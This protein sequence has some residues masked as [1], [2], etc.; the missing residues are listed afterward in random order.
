MPIEL[1]ARARV[2]D[3]KLADSLERAGRILL[4]ALERGASELEITLV[5]DDEMRALNHR[6][7]G[8]QRSTDVLSFA[9]LEGEQLASDVGAEHLG[10]VVISVETAEVQA[11]RGGWSLIEECTRL[12]LHGLL[13]LL[14]HEHERGGA[15]AKRM[16]AEERRLSDVLA[17]AGLPCARDPE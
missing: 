2:R 3:S 12:L 6:Y 4:E 9:Q 17:A 16:R 5:D 10:D 11:E 15:E 14:G 7:R 8:K 13:H 1:S